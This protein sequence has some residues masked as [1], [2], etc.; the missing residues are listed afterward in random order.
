MQLRTQKVIVNISSILL[1][2]AFFLF[3]ISLNEPLFISLN[4][5]L[6]HFFPSVMLQWLTDYG[7][8]I[9]FFFIFILLLLYYPKNAILGIAGMLIAVVLCAL[10]K[11]TLNFPRPA[12]LLLLNDFYTVGYVPHHHSFPSGHTLRAFI[13]FSYAYFLVPQSRIKWVLFLLAVGAGLSRI[14]V[15]AHW[16]LDVIVGAVLPIVSFKL[17]LMN[18]V[19]LVFSKQRQLY[20][21]F[22]T[23]FFLFFI[24]SVVK[25]FYFKSTV[26]GLFV[27]HI[28]MLIILC[29]ELVKHAILRSNSLKSPS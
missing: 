26:F 16:P 28:L 21:C 7:D 13:L 17:I 22:V 25:S 9:V 6:N 18:K 27:Q 20:W 1:I 23:L 29:F 3:T 5:T 10:L 11:Y 4:S 8:N 2:M 19:R 12:D 24:Y 14:A 15:G